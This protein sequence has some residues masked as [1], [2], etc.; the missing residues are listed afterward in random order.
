MTEPTASLGEGVAALASALNLLRNNC[1]DAPTQLALG[2]I[3]S[4]LLDTWEDLLAKELDATT[5]SYRDALKAV[6]N[7]SGAA[8]RA[9]K[10]V[11]HVAHVV[12]L[13]TQAAEAVGGALKA[14]VRG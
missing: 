12:R 3:A 14:A 9:L 5:S 13:A 2:E 10:D 11:Q 1:T 4:A 6:K 7:A 8:D